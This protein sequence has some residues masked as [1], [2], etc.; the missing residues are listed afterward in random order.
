MA[1][2]KLTPVDLSDRDWQASSHRGVAIVRAP[3]EQAA[4]NAAQAAFGVKT[5]FPPGEGVKA[6]PWRRPAL[7]QAERIKDPSFDPEGPTEVLQPSVP[8]AAQ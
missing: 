6:P 8:E 5:G 7:A 4:R 3:T 2:W 1:I